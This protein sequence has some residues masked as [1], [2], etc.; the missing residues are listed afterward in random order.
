M[1]DSALT[2][3]NEDHLMLFKN[4]LDRTF[5][6]FGTSAGFFLMLGGIGATLFSPF[7]I[8]L[9]FIGAFICFTTSS[10]V[11]DTGKKRARLTDDIFGIIPLGKWIDLDPGMK[12]GLKRFHR[13]YAAYSRGS[14]SMDIHHNDLRIFLYTSKNREIMP[15]KKIA[16][17]GSPEDELKEMGHLLGLE[18]I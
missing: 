18:I 9:A 5:G 4:K 7:A 13:G 16:P 8:L 17:G 11:I 12:I 14:Q 6:P 10:A 15:L 1:A 2:A 3:A